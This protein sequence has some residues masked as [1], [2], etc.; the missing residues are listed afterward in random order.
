V[1]VSL[2]SQ[3][4]LDPI[5]LFLH[6]LQYV[7]IYLFFIS[8]FTKCCC[9]NQIEEMKLDV[10]GMIGPETRHYFKLFLGRFPCY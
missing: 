3:Y 7:I 9:D 8:L 2:E 6:L 5:T 1:I 4:S 10:R